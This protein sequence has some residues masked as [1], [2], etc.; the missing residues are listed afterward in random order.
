M[1]ELKQNVHGVQLPKDAVLSACVAYV[2][3][4]LEQIN[5]AIN[6]DRHDDV[7]RSPA[8]FPVHEGC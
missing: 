7:C 5:V 8:I 6:L 1:M 3:L 4:R 2:C